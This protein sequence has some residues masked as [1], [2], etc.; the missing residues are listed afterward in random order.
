MKKSITSIVHH[1]LKENHQEQ[2]KNWLAEVIAASSEY[3]GYIDT[4]FIDN[5]GNPNEVISIFRFDNQDNL[6]KWLESS[7]HQSFLQNLKNIVEDE[8]IIKS[9]KGLEYWFEEQSEET[10]KMSILTYIGLLPLVVV[11][12][13]PLQK[14]LGFQ[15][16]TL[17]WT[18]T[19]IIVLLMSYVMMPLVLR[20]YN[21]LRKSLN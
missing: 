20:I 15:G 16:F 17:T 7:T 11:I 14:F 10:F 6:N 8:T 1:Q 3:Q 2:F 5:T 12:P 21:S 13:I 18:S 9:Y 19:A 4:K